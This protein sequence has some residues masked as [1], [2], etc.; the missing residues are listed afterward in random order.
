MSHCPEKIAV[1]AST[2][3]KTATGIGLEW[4]VIS[5]SPKMP[6][7]W[8]ARGAPGSRAPTTP[9]ISLLSIPAS[10][11]AAM[12]AWAPSFAGDTPPASRLNSVEPTPTIAISSRIGFRLA[13]IQ[14]SRFLKTGKGWP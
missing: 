9:S 7:I 2:S 3:A 5:L 11:I 10:W 1:I 4:C 8:L 12:H 14:P 6:D 13:M